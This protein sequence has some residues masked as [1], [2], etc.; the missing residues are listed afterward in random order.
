[1]KGYSKCESCGKF[2]MNCIE[3]YSE[4]SLS[5]MYMCNTCLKEFEDALSE[6]G[7]VYETPWWAEDEMI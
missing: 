6:I 7:N 1:M 2:D 3:Y 5:P 4:V